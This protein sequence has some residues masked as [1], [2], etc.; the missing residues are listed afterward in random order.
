MS[1]IW[2]E[3][4]AARLHWRA[5]TGPIDYPEKTKGRGG[6]PLNSIG[7]SRPI[8]NFVPPLCVVRQGLL[9]A[10]PIHFFRAV[11]QGLWIVIPAH[12]GREK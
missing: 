12:W 7:E 11:S 6:S 3:E 2:Q 8:L 9:L 10:V 5:Q 1:S 4:C